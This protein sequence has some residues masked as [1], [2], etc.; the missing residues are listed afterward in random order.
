[1]Y[2]FL[3]QLLH[4][5]NSYGDF[6]KFRVFPHMVSATNLRRSYV[7]YFSLGLT[8]HSPSHTTGVYGSLAFLEKVEM[9]LTVLMLVGYLRWKF[10]LVPPDLWIAKNVSC[11][12]NIFIS[13]VRIDINWNYR[14]YQS[15]KL[16]PITEWKH[17]LLGEICSRQ[18]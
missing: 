9:I 4:D 11:V 12:D 7:W 10:N 6:V 16:R 1:M 3:T 17:L 2:R 15:V 5:L 14:R 8:L 13:V 18:V